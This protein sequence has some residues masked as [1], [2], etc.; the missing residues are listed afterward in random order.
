[1]L[2]KLYGD[3][4]AITRFV[5]SEIRTGA[6]NLP[7]LQVGLDAIA[8]GRLRVVDDVSPEELATMQALPPK[9]SAADKTNIAVAGHRKWTLLTDERAML[10]ECGR[11]TIATLRTEDVLREAVQAGILK[12]D[13]LPGIAD[14]M[15]QKAKYRPQI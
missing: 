6:A 10:A 12:Q 13:D 2:E 8:A 4:L 14:E 1:V 3:G 7:K 9:F 5:E 11:R 15:A